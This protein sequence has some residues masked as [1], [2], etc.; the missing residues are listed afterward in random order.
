MDEEFANDLEL[1]EVGSVVPSPPRMP[2]LAA[3]IA[4]STEETHIQLGY[5]AGLLPDGPALKEEG[6]RGEVV[7]R[8][9]WT[10][11]PPGPTHSP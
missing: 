5:H 3:S 2:S 7:V 11:N 4:D 10:R 9:A 1:P 6:P 8:T